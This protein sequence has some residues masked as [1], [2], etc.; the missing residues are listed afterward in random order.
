MTR[1]GI[2]APVFSRIDD[3]MKI[4]LSM[5]D[6][7]MILFSGAAVETISTPELSRAE[8]DRPFL[9]A[10]PY[11][12]TPV[13]LHVFVLQRVRVEVAVEIHAAAVEDVEGDGHGHLRRQQ[14]AHHG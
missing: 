14:L 7:P 12:D 4:A 11:E 1:N 2:R 6:S 9:V 10:R 5:D 13:E 3:G 8:A